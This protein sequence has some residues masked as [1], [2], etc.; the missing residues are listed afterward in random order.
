MISWSQRCSLPARCDIAAAKIINKRQI[1]CLLECRPVENLKRRAEGLIC[2]AAVQNGL[3]MNS[4]HPRKRR[5]RLIDELF[6]CI[7]MRARKHSQRGIKNCFG[8]RPF[9]VPVDRGLNSLFQ[10]TS[11]FICVSPLSDRAKLQNTH[12]IRQDHRPVYRIQR[13]A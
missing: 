3:T 8:L 6:E 9:P 12:S 1:D 10:D 4:D 2:R 5:I 13:C 7:Q 11:F